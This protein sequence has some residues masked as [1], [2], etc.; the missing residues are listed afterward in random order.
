[1]EKAAS[2]PREAQG[3][4]KTL[5]NQVYKGM[6]AAVKSISELQLSISGLRWKDP[7]GLCGGPNHGS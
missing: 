4:T 7:F 5:R 6:T 1:M 2:S 3:K